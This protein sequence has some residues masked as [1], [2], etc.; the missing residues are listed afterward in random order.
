MNSLE[1]GGI[2]PAP[3]CRARLAPT[4][5]EREEISRAVV[6]GT[7]IRAIAFSLGP[8]PS[9]VSR[10]IKHNDGL[11]RYRAALA[12]QHTWARGRRP[13]PCKLVVN[14]KLADIV[15]GTL[16]LENLD[17][18]AR[19]LNE[20]PRKTRNCERPAPRFHACVASTD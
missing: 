3:R 6:A 16:K 8:A 11:E 14:Q 20:R 4:L 15:A 1:T 17:E 18:V 9:T 13:K 19:L 2:C 5:A 12:D 7:S 10:E